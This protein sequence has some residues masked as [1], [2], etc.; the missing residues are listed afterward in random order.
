MPHPIDQRLAQI[1]RRVRHVVVAYGL[2]WVTATVLSA[3]VVVCLGDWLFHFDDPGV[4][5][6]LEVGLVALCAGLVRRFLWSPLRLPLRDL[7]LALRVEER[8]PGFQDSLA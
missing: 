4:R 2:S 7:D 6:I 1:R 5:L 8:Y 3:V